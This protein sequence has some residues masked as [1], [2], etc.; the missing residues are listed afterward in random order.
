MILVTFILF[1]VY[2]RHQTPDAVLQGL[3]GRSERAQREDR[4]RPSHPVPQ[5]LQGKTRLPCHERDGNRNGK[6]LNWFE[7]V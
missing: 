3:P 7:L 2:R 1:F 4:E 6:S 5:Q